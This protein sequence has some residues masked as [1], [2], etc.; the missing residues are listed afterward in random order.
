MYQVFIVGFGLEFVYILL[1]F[2]SNKFY[3][4][5]KVLE[6]PIFEISR[7][8][9]E[10]VEAEDIVCTVNTYSFYDIIK[11]IILTDPIPKQ[12]KSIDM[13]AII[14]PQF[15]NSLSEKHLKALFVTSKIMSKMKND[16]HENSEEASL[17]ENHLK[18]FLVAATLYENLKQKKQITHKSEPINEKAMEIAKQIKAM[19]VIKKWIGYVLQ[20]RREKSKQDSEKETA[21]TENEVSVVETESMASETDNLNSEKA[22]KKKKN[23]KRN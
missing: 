5:I 11:V 8:F 9:A 2:A 16:T 17:T 23:R 1:R 7:W 19:I 12:K 13:E 6:M 14:P 18:A 3:F 10:Y 22:V 15:P 20:R 21:P 4:G